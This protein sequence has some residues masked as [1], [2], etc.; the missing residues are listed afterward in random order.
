MSFHCALIRA[1]DGEHPG[2]WNTWLRFFV[3]GVLEIS[4]QAVRQI[5]KLL[6]LH[7]RY[8]ELLHESSRAGTRPLVDQLFQNPYITVAVAE[9]AMRVS[10]PTARAAITFLE[11]KKILR[12][13]TGREW[14][15]MYLAYEILDVIGSDDRAREQ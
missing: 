8:T 13:V 1:A 2:G 15:R 9:K 14:R 12:E 5:T 6:E 10:N 3:N 11:E 7:R 4:Q